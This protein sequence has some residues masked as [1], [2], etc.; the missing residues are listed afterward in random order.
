MS[1]ADSVV[2]SRPTLGADAT[3]TFASPFPPSLSNAKG[4]GCAWRRVAPTGLPE[5]ASRGRTTSAQAAERVR[6]CRLTTVIVPPCHRHRTP[7][8]PKV[9]MGFFVDERPAGTASSLRY[10]DLERHSLAS[11]YAVR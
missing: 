3:T 10:R 6:R 4:A 1:S 5:E 2:T 11:R 7:G 9:I 8:L